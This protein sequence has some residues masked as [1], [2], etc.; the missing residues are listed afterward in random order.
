MKNDPYDNNELPL[1]KTTALSFTIRYQSI[2]TKSG[3]R[4]TAQILSVSCRGGKSTKRAE[5]VAE[6]VTLVDIRAFSD[7]GKRCGVTA[8]ILDGQRQR[9]GDEE[10]DYPG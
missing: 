5:H 8:F 7:H 9:L 1:E 2:H 4:N 3:S 10:R 6:G